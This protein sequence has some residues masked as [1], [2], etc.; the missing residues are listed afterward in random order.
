MGPGN[1]ASGMPLPTQKLKDMDPSEELEKEEQKRQKGAMAIWNH[2]RA[3]RRDVKSGESWVPMT[4]AAR[5][6]A[7]S[8]NEKRP[9]RMLL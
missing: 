2:R 4:C 8:R 3:W 6:S 9:L 5:R 1:V 7:S